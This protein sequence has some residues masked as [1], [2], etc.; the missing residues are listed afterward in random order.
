MLDP[1]IYW[2]KT[3]NDHRAR[4]PFFPK[5]LKMICAIGCPRLLPIKASRSWPMQKVRAMFTATS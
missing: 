1:I 5:L 3:I 2:P 4:V